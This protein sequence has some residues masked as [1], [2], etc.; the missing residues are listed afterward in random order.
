MSLG[1]VIRRLLGPAFP[2]LGRL[3]R[4]IFIDLAMVADC[5]PPVPSG[6]R[7][8]D[9]GGGDGEILNGVLA[10][11]PDIRVMM[12]DIASSIGTSLKPEFRDRVMVLP[13]TSL[14][15]YQAG[16][17]AFPDCILL[18][19]VLHHIPVHERQAFFRH[20]REFVRGRPVEIVVLD[21]EPGHLRSRLGLLSDK[22]IT[23]DRQVVLIS[24]KQVI[25]LMRNSF[26]KALWRETCLYDRDK[27][28][29]CLVF[30]VPGPVPGLSTGQ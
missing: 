15:A 30:K 3:Y 25:E 26:P 23:G 6:S 24:R 10:R 27:P 20:L 9:I 21:V 16:N 18:S 22:Y 8:L 19:C 1:K 14:E 7:I 12:I 28:N 29:Y 13:S 2:A 17:D 4:S 11:R 5:F